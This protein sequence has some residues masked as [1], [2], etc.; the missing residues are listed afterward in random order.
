[1]R[2]ALVALR[3]ELL[4][5]LQKRDILDC[6]WAMLVSTFM[7]GDTQGVLAILKLRFFLEQHSS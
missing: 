4:G 2:D 1:M 7:I 6:D 3:E 5:F